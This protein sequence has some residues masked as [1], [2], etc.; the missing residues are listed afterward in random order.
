MG[1]QPIDRTGGLTMQLAA[2]RDLAIWIAH[3]NNGWTTHAT[4]DADGVFHASAARCGASGFL[5]Q[6]V[7]LDEPTAKA[8]AMLALAQQ[9]GHA[10]CTGECSGWRQY[11]CLLD[12][13]SEE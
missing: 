13:L 11:P 12:L 3:H 7:E 5:T 10:N 6:Y 1:R 8:A 2:R 4:E 9:T